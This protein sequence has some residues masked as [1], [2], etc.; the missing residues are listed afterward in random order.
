MAFFG[1]FGVVARNDDP[2]IV[3]LDAEGNI[4][5]RL[6]AVGLTSRATQA[7]TRYPAAVVLYDAE[8]NVIWMAPR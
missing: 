5:S 7:L 2:A 3:L 4:R 6:G 8:G 1:P